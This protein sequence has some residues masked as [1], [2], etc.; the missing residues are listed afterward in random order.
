MYLKFLKI[1]KDKE[2]I[3]HIKFKRGINLIVDISNIENQKESE[4]TL[5]KLPFLD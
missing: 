1:E 2:I 4:T 3:R 5:E